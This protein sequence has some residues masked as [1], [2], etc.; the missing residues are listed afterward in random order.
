[1]TFN[2]DAI[3]L[4]IEIFDCFYTI[5]SLKSAKNVQKQPSKDQSNQFLFFV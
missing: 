3:I 4:G 5:S 1:M 2:P